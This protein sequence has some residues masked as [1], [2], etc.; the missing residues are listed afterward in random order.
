MTNISAWRR[1]GKDSATQK[2]ISLYEHI[3]SASSR[4]V[5]IILDPFCECATTV[6][7]AEKLN[8]H[9][10]ACPQHITVDSLRWWQHPSTDT[11][12]ETAAV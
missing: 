8:C 4:E 12:T 7:V 6:V 11:Q 2:P 5:D 1:E 10:T 9:W 3:V